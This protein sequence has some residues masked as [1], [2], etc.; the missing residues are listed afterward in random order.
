MSKEWTPCAESQH[1]Y[2]QEYRAEKRYCRILNPKKNG[3]PPFEDGKCKFYKS[4]ES[5]FSGGRKDGR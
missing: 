3:E 5:D 4:K 1:C 2:Y